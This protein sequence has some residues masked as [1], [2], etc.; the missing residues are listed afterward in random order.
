MNVSPRTLTLSAAIVL[1]A[2]SVVGALLV[3]TDFGGG[4]AA[5]GAL[6]L[7]NLLLWT[8]T[9]RGL[10]A[11][12]LEGRAPVLPAVLYSLKLLVLAAGL[13]LLCSVFPPTAVVIGASVV[14]F[15]ILGHAAV[16]M[17]TELQVGEG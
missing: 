16:G 14:V 2:A 7:V 8:A 13:S 17:G 3:D 5:T 12:S 1:V 11:A 15:G 4:I 10:F 6:M 9:V